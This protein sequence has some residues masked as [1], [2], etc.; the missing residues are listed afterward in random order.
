[1]G[2]LNRLYDELPEFGKYVDAYCKQRN[3]TKDQALKHI[4][5]QETAKYYQEKIKDRVDTDTK[6][7]AKELGEGENNNG[8]QANNQDIYDPT[9]HNI[10][11]SCYQVGS[12]T[13]ESMEHTQHGQEYKP[14]NAGKNMRG[15]WLRD[16]IAGIIKFFT[17]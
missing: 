17:L 3:L 10:C 1:M 13:P 12:I 8:L 11:R 5:V 4:T 9:S 14:E 7:I 2:D 6:K 15:S 16:R